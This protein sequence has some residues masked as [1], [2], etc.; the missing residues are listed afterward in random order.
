MTTVHLLRHGEVHN[1]DR[2]L[3][4][5]LPGFKLSKLGEAQAKLAA[6]YLRQFDIGY[7]VSSPLER[8]L[9][10]AEPIA[11]M[12]GL[13]VATDD[14][15]L[16]ADNK[17]QGR[18]VAG[19]KGLFTDVSNWKYFTNP[20]RPSWGEPYAQIAA[21]VLAAARDARDAAHGKDAVVVSHQLPIVCARRFA[22]GKRLFHDPRR[23]QCALA[24]VTSLVFD[25]DRVVR[26]DYAEPAATLPPG[27]GAGA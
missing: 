7:L 8:A 5:R 9:Q 14:R 10:T 3:Y 25:N 2:V 11:G 21:R 1:P 24:S 22:E 26:V 6:E 15:L 23:R 13:D 27:H 12:L 18:N 4:G 20:F 19:G 16:E 17:L